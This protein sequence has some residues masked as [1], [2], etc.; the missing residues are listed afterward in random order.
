MERMSLCPRCHLPRKAPQAP[1]PPTVLAF[2]FLQ[3]FSTRTINLPN[4]SNPLYQ[5][6]SQVL[7]FAIYSKQQS[8]QANRVSSMVRARVTA[9]GKARPRGSLGC[10]SLTV[11]VTCWIRELT[12]F[13]L[14]QQI[15]SQAPL[16][17]SIRTASLALITHLPLSRPY[18]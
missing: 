9:R 12:Q 8:I 3:I 1:H 6:Q 5:L 13:R 7:P 17:F 16:T 10:P 14:G 2:S 4:E 18:R 15:Y 11:F